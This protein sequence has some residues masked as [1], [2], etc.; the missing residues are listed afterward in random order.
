MRVEL[1]AELMGQLVYDGLQSELRKVGANAA[2]LVA[3]WQGIKPSGRAAFERIAGNLANYIV[4]R[5]YCDAAQLGG[6]A[7][8]REQLLNCLLDTREQHIYNLS[9]ENRELR[10]AINAIPNAPWEE[11]RWTVANMEVP[12]VELQPEPPPDGGP[13]SEPWSAN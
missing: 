9:V 4:E 11:D 7:G 8:Y 10:E 2:L 5:L 1:N 12:G 13:Q 3:P 6:E